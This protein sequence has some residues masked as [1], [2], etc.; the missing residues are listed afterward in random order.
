MKRLL[1]IAFCITPF[2]AHAQTA[3]PVASQTV[4]VSWTKPTQNTDNTVI[5]GTVLYNVYRWSAGVGNVTKIADGINALKFVDNTPPASPC[6]L[7]SAVVDAKAESLPASVCTGP[8]PGSP[9]GVQVS[10]TLI[11]K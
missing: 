7:V 3:A 5:T 11:F 10:V 1:L 8:T 9:G 2:I 6:Y 4:T